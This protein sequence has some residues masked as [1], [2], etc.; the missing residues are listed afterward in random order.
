MPDRNV[1]SWTAIIDG[2][3]K[4]GRAMDA[5]HVFEQMKHSGTMPNLITFISVLSACSHA[6]LVDQGWHYF[7]TMTQI[8][9]LIPA[10]EHYACM[11]D[12]LGRA[13]QLDEAQNF[14]NKMP[15]EPGADVWGALLGACRVHDNIELGKLAAEQ[16]FKLNA[17]R[18]GAYV[19]LSNIYAAAG[20]WDDASKVRKVMKERGINKEPG[21]SWIEV[22][23]KSTHISCRG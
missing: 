20:R 10:Q 8:Y 5:I 14:I 17:K 6:G 1:I 13:G 7:N 19:V 16:L 3:G 12:L 11:V 2:H 4:H 18:A 23:K 21:C 15:I 9:S 22:E